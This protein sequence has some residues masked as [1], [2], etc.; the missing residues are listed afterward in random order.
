MA[1]AL[2][3]GHEAIAR[4]TA[5]ERPQLVGAG[6]G[7]RENRLLARLIEEAFGRPLLVPCHREEAAFGAA[8][9]AGVGAG[10]YADLADAGSLVRYY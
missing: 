7:V 5:S 8:L 3:T 10:V 6:N 2:F 9:L 4:L 1:R